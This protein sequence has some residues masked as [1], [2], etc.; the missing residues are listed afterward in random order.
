MK[1][2]E[3]LETVG[4]QK[5]LLIAQAKAK[6]LGISWTSGIN[7]IFQVC[8]EKFE[9]APTHI[10]AKGGSATD[11]I[12]KWVQKY[13]DA[14]NNRISIHRS[15]LPST[16][17]DPIIDVIIQ[18]RLTH[19]GVPA[20]NK[21]K[22]AHRLSMSAE[23]ILGLLLEEYLAIHLHPKG[24]HCAWGETLRSVD[25]C[26]SKGD[27]L[28]IKNRSN[29]ENSSSS[30]VR[31]GTLIEKWF[32]VDAGSGKYLWPEFNSNYNVNCT[33]DNFRAFVRDALIHNPDAL[34]IEPGNPWLK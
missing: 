4:K 1:F 17:A 16:V 23:N 29:S 7:C 31:V 15:N 3:A 25:F 26:S 21:I 22:Y 14:Y 19:L 33:E 18:G 6:S 30:R 9:L 32:R 13:H 34:A 24:W 10:S 8:L 2:I 20:L 5:S 12:G 27:L 28:Q 11:V